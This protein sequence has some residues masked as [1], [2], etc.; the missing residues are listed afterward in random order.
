MKKYNRLETIANMC[1]GAKCVADI[2]C[3]HAKLCVHLI[4]NCGVARAIASEISQGPRDNA[5]RTITR[6]NLQDKIST[7]LCDGLDGLAPHDCDTIV[8]AGMGAEEICAIIARA[9]WLRE[10]NHTLVLQAM[11]HPERMRRYL[12]ENGFAIIDEKIIADNGWIYTAIKAIAG[13][14]C[15][16]TAQNAYLFSD[17]I[18]KDELFENFCARLLRKYK[19]L[20][21]NRA[22]ANLQDLGE[23]AIYN[24][25][26]KASGGQNVT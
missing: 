8:I 16:K 21:E 1:V 22:N 12:C 6:A 4:K 3:D 18:T 20:V 2:G 26:L 14:D 13:V 5:I 15:S 17:F 19:K 7:I 11:T 24:M 10:G 25:L 23:I 9:Q